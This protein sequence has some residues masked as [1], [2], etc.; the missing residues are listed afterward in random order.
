MFLDSAFLRAVLLLGV[1][2]CALDF[3]RVVLSYLAVRTLGDVTQAAGV[4]TLR[5]ANA[6]A[7]R[8]GRRIVTA[9]DVQAALG[10]SWASVIPVVPV[11][12]V[13]N[14]W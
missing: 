3:T 10:D 9:T 8:E 6:Q 2:D 11:V 7:R 14:P 13:G 5:R 12:P 4:A 1:D